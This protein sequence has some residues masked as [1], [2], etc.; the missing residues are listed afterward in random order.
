MWKRIWSWMVDREFERVRRELK[1]TQ[2]KLDAAVSRL[3][4]IEY[5]LNRQ[6]RAKVVESANHQ[7]AKGFKAWPPFEFGAEGVRRYLSGE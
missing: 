2:L 4:A 3:E 5:F 7:F 1:E 6:E